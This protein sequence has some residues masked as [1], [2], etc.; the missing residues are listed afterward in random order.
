[1]L[2]LFLQFVV[3]KFKEEDETKSIEE[4]PI[5]WIINEKLPVEKE[6][7]KVLWPPRGMLFAKALNVKLHQIES[8]WKIYDDIL[9]KYLRQNINDL[10]K[11]LINFCFSCSCLMTS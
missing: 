6:K 10:N 2:Y 7:V 1:M 9:L 4:V 3:I 5:T 11:F 8:D